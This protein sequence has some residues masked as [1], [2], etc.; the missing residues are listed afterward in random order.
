MKNLNPD[1]EQKKFIVTVLPAGIPGEHSNEL[2]ISACLSINKDY[3]GLAPTPGT[4]ND[5]AAFYTALKALPDALSQATFLCDGTADAITHIEYVKKPLDFWCNEVADSKT[6]FAKLKLELWARIFPDKKS[7]TPTVVPKRRSVKTVE[8]LFS[9]D[10]SSGLNDMIN[11][12]T[13]S[14]AAVKSPKLAVKSLLAEVHK[15]GK[16]NDELAKAELL[17]FTART[18][19]NPDAFYT[20]LFT[21]SGPPDG[22]GGPLGLS[23]ATDDYLHSDD[24]DLDEVLHSFN[25]ACKEPA[26][27]RIMG[28][29][30]DYKITFKESFVPAAEKLFKLQAILQDS[31]E[32]WSIP[33]QIHAFTRNGKYGYLINGPG[34]HYKNSILQNEGSELVRFDKLSI[35]HKDSPETEDALTRGIIYNN[36]NLHDII[37]PQELPPDTTGFFCT[38]EFLTSGHRV[39]AL[40]EEQGKKS[41]YSLT[42]RRLELKLGTE[43]KPFYVCDTYQS[44]IHFDTPAAF[45]QDGETQHV[46]SGSLFEYTGELLTLK[47]AFA[48]ASEKTPAEKAT[49]LDG[50]HDDG[51]FKSQKRFKDIVSF[52]FYPFTEVLSPT[53]PP[54]LNCAYGIPSYFTQRDSPKLRFTNADTERKYTFVVHQEYLNGWGLPLHSPANSVQIGVDELLDNNSF[55]DPIQFSPIE[56]KKPVLLFHTKKVD[57]S[58]STIQS[59]K[60]DLDTLVVRSEN[61][62]DRRPEMNSRHVLPERIALEH[63]FWYDLLSSKKMPPS[64]SFE[65]KRRYNCPFHS[66]A[67]YETYV[68]EKFTDGPN[69]GKEKGLLCREGCHK[70]CGGTQMEAY[71]SSNKITP[72]YLADPAVVGFSMQLYWD[73]DHRYQITNGAASINFGGAPGIQPES[74]LLNA[75]GA[76]RNEATMDGH[77]INVCL[78]PGTIVYGQLANS[79]DKKY[80]LQLSDRWWKD[81]IQLRALTNAPEADRNPPKPVIFVHAVKKPLVE[82]EIFNLFSTPAERMRVEHVRTWLPRLRPGSYEIGKNIIGERISKTQPGSQIESTLAQVNLKAHFERLD[83]IDIRVFLEKETPTGILELWVRKEEYIDDPT[84]IVA[85]PGTAGAG[86]GHCPEDP[87][88][89]FDNSKNTFSLEKVI[90]FT[91]DVMSQLKD[92]E[93][94]ESISAFDDPYRSIISKIVLQYDFKTTKFEER[95]YFL[96]CTSKFRGYFTTAKPLG[97]DFN[98][99]KLQRDEYSLPELK[100]ISTKNSLHFKVMTLNNKRPEKPAVEYAITT[101]QEKRTRKGKETESIQQGNVV[102][103]YFKRGRLT[104]G[105]RER[106]GVIVQSDGI[107]SKIFQQSNFLSQAGKD[108]I[109]DSFGTRNQYLQFNDIA[110]AG[111][112]PYDAYFDNELGLYSYLPKFDIAKQLWK[113]E[114]EINPLTVDGRQLHNPF[115]NFALVHHQPF[116]VNYNTAGTTLGDIATDLRISEVEKSAWCYLLPERKLS[117]HFSKP[118]LLSDHGRVEMKLSFDFES[119]HIHHHNDSSKGVFKIRS[120]FILTIEGTRDKVNWVPVQSKIMNPAAGVGVPALNHPLL[121]LKMLAEAPDLNPGVNFIATEIAFERTSTA[122]QPAYKDF[123]VRLVEV[124]WFTDDPWENITNVDPTQNDLLRVRY[125]ELIS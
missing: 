14:T 8:H 88:T 17:Q 55:P 22:L 53:K 24:I 75:I 27:M 100:E 85:M 108:I 40:I 112:S 5:F 81:L 122:R 74:R 65:W 29:A 43:K 102:T 47:S 105:G 107:Y 92:P 13:R 16:A 42:G 67:E 52:S 98:E 3:S 111:D 25:A 83:A 60:E 64:V 106:I 20:A 125:V 78:K 97:G 36:S 61:A 86:I 54:Y 89:P 12:L 35:E 71:Y 93:N 11:R 45:I 91:N 96:R 118:N 26:L 120:N 63:A 9:P 101:I 62:A 79:I 51:L 41:L 59:S 56:N 30:C 87:V 21:P 116:S 4:T 109:S 104:S 32:I 15:V 95:E 57:E 70:F 66:K 114:V 7:V 19:K 94:T 1:R 117:V 76:D 115:I 69:K 68:T 77:A 39:G 37:K 119:L 33:T 6:D 103:I 44:S 90:D 124:E 10:R 58:D 31:T 2:I 50:Y 113:I 121:D 84:Q 18:L 72:N 73:S 48:K 110:I 46:T 34:A 99:A 28:L 82:P 38:D 80:Q 23:K 49:Q 123:R